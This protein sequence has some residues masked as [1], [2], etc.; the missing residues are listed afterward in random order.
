MDY[1]IS[2]ALLTMP[3]H[4]SRYFDRLVSSQ[5]IDSTKKRRQKRYCGVNPGI[6]ALRLYV[7]DSTTT[8][9]CI[10]SVTHN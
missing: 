4:A 2:F 1:F 3:Y 7:C 6:V 5:K 8:N 10:P 9:N